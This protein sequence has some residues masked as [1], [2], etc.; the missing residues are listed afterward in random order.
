MLST[1]TAAAELGEIT[2]ALPIESQIELFLSGASD[3]GPLL[4]ALYDH[5]LDE[6]IPDHLRALCRTV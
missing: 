1:L 3:G 4:G 5:V 2:S 6:V